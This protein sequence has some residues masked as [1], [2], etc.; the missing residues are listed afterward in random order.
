[1]APCL[2]G[3]SALFPALWHTPA[4]QLRST[5]SLDPAAPCRMRQRP[6]AGR[7]LV[8]ITSRSEPNRTVLNAYVSKKPRMDS[9]EYALCQI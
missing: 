7:I 8:T 5:Q 1:M 2:H 3:P 6:T 9:L 4:A